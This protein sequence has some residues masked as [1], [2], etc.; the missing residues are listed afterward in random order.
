[1]PLRLKDGI[2]YGWIIV[3]V[4]LL[5][6]A[7]LMGIASS[8]TIFF[9]S[10]EAEFELTRTAT[11]AIS[12]VSMV[13]IPISGFFGGWALDR[14]GPRI[15]LF[16]M[17]LITGL[18]LVLTSR[19]GA[20]WQIFLTYSVL[21]AIGMGPVYVVA[22]STV[23]R[24]FNKKRGLAVGIAGSGEGLGTITMA[25]LSNFLISRFSWKTAYLI[26]GLITWAVVIP[27]SR[28]LKKEPGEI[29]AL[30]DGLK[31]KEGDMSG[32]S[33]DAQP[34]ESGMTLSET[35]KTRGFW[36]VAGI[37]FFFS[38]CMSMVLTH[39]V[40]H[41][42]DIGITATEGAMIISIM[43]AARVAGM[44]GL[45]IVADRAGRKKVAV[46]STLVQAGAMVWLVWVQELWMFYVF[47]VIYG[48]GNG[49]LFSG[50][51]SLLGDTFGLNRLGAI[52][53][54]LEIGWGIGAG[55]GPL[56]GGF[57]YD[58]SSSYSLAFILGAGSMAAI[59]FLVVMLRSASSHQH[60]QAGNDKPAR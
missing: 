51:T 50:V 53:G 17:G 29:G 31:A 16:V 21:L 23:S 27:L 56:I 14:Y 60:E 5:I 54:L 10:I 4:F 39:I 24:W 22:T 33:V 19:T 44:I 58:T 34:Q 46:L 15:V 32:V 59:T 52:L 7:V 40:P 20:A 13:L 48:L 47:A 9:K 43:G 38:F 6:Q 8:F 25:P 42:T 37:W 57:I 41:V 45:G 36:A 12:S 11:S 49:G 35:L 26:I 2:F 3:V 1:M 18:S 30:P 28:L 55:I